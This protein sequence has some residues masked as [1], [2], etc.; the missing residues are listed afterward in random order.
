[1]IKKYTYLALFVCSVV[2]CTPSSAVNTAVTLTQP[3]ATPNIVASSSG[4]LNPTQQPEAPTAAASLTPKVVDCPSFV[5]GLPKL[6]GNAPKLILSGL[7][8]SSG[9]GYL[10]LD[11]AHGDL[12]RINEDNGIPSQGHTSP[13]NRLLAY[14]LTDYGA[15]GPKGI[16]VRD[17]DM[18][19]VASM[20]WESE[21]QLIAGWLDNEHLLISRYSETNPD[22]YAELESV[23]LQ[24][25][26]RTKLPAGFPDL[27]SREPDPL[28]GWFNLNKVIYDPEVRW[29]IYPNVTN[30]GEDQIVLRDLTLQARILTVTGTASIRTTPKWSAVRKTVVVSGSQSMLSE[31]RASEGNQ[32]DLYELGPDDGVRSITG[33]LRGWPALEI[34]EYSWDHS[35]QR[36]AVASRRVGGAGAIGAWRGVVDTL[37]IL[38]LQRNQFRDLCVPIDNKSEPLWMPGDRYLV[39]WIVDPNSAEH[40]LVYFI[41]VEMNIAY[42]V[43]RDYSPIG[44]MVSA[45]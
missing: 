40:A 34:G 8:L 21:W 4:D 3:L 14:A 43:V 13:N 16:R 28:W 29:A 15:A 41:D 30:D 1:M 26:E 22:G 2:A 44:W 11:V 42:L 23:S 10:E 35:G 7:G 12:V 24:S 31:M 19:L 18:G 20:D 32:L 27:F 39:A 6:T 45:D 9:P 17:A 5:E 33:A 37:G 36:I 38:D 25:G